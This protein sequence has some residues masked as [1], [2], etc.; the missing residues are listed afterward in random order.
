M[1]AERRR[2]PIGMQTFCTIREAGY[3]Y[4]GKY[5][6]FGEPIHLVGV[7]SSEEACNIRA[8]DVAEA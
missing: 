3:Y 8:L 5:G 6:R 4:A 7:E 1:E 2:L